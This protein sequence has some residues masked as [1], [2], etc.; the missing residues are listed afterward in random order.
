MWTAASPL[1]PRLT[2][3]S[4]NSAG[5]PLVLGPSPA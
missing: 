5:K 3:P 2:A 4:R 1:R